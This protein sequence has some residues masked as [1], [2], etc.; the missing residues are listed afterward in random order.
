MLTIQL[1]FL[2]SETLT[3]GSIT[4]NFPLQI[5]VKN[6]F[7]H[8]TFGLVVVHAVQV[9]P[10]FGPKLGTPFYRKF[11]PILSPILEEYPCQ[12]AF[13]QAKRAYWSL[14][15]HVPGSLCGGGPW[16]WCRW[17]RRS[18]ASRPPACTL[19]RSGRT[20]CLAKILLQC[21]DLTL[22]THYSL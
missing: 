19:W 21:L 8:K 20:S 17:G 7:Q 6:Y 14:S 15:N 11:W 1:M 12:M 4:F 3:Q 2:T 16:W 5:W 13:F 18:P 22:Y 9:Q 10:F